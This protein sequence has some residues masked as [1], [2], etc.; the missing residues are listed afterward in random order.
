MKVGYQGNVPSN[1]DALETFLPGAEAIAY[2]RLPEL[3]DA[4]EKAGVDRAFVPVESS[5]GGSFGESYDLMLKHAVNVEG[6]VVHGADSD[7][8]R[9]FSLRSGEWNSELTVTGD[10][11]GKTSLVFTV[12]HKAGSLVR[13]LTCFSRQQVSLVYLQSRPSHRQPW[14]YLFF[15]D[16]E[17]YS[18]EPRVRTALRELTR[19]NPFVRILGS[20]PASNDRLHAYSSAAAGGDP[21]AD[22]GQEAEK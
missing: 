22:A 1:K 17:G 8:T 10:S 18:H 6:E 20:Y 2:D 11:M 4:L 7:A 14:E 15:A 5:R 13:A 3:F 9:F 21:L 12:E 19:L 16:V